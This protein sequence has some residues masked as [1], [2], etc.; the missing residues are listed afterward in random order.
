MEPL[1]PSALQDGGDDGHIPQNFVKT[2][3]ITILVHEAA[4][5]DY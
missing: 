4:A 3:M 5:Q 1:I 2:K